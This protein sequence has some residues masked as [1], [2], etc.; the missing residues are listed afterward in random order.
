MIERGGRRD[1][2]MET[3]QQIAHRPG[4]RVDGQ[5]PLDDRPAFAQMAMNNKP[6]LD[7]IHRAVDPL[8]R[9]RQ[10]IVKHQ[11]PIETGLDRLVKPTPRLRLRQV[12]AKRIA[13][14]LYQRLAADR[15]AQIARQRIDEA[16]PAVQ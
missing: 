13:F 14:A 4:N 9:V 11:Q 2:V 10:A 5:C 6:A 8:D 7:R 3:A 12:G 1:L 16:E 15:A